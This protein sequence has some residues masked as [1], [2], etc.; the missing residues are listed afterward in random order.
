MDIH[1]LHLISYLVAVAYL[2]AWLVY[3]MRRFSGW[4]RKAGFIRNLVGKKCSLNP[5]AQNLPWKDILLA[6]C[7]MCLGWALTSWIGALFVKDW[8]LLFLC[9]FG[10]LSQ[11]LRP[12]KREL[13]LLPVMA[14]IAGLHDQHKE[15][16]DLFDRLSVVV[17]GL[18]P[19]EVQKA[20]REAL[21]RRRSGFTI[22]QCCGVLK[23][24]SPFLDE[25]IYTLRLSVWQTVPAFDLALERLRER[26]GRQW[27][28]TSKALLFK[29]KVR[30]LQQFC[31]S[32]ILGALTFL[33]I[34]GRLP[35]MLVWPSFAVIGCIG[36]GCVVAAGLLTVGLTQPWLNRILGTAILAASLLPLLLF[37]SPPRL[38]EIQVHRVMHISQNASANEHPWEQYWAENWEVKDSWP[39]P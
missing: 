39:N 25:L 35:F 38:A 22:E 8:L 28:R 1:P 33:V 20:V 32:L 24:L 15:G 14:L 9:G 36:L 5:P 18:P 31:W 34:D 10:V 30:P 6:V 17:D 2:V 16:M 13:N 23:G 26:A 4:V 37:A 27:D 29:E 3:G 7:G 21:Q 19:G 12:S 11:E